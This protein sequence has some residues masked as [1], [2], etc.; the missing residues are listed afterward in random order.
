LTLNGRL[1]K[2]TWPGAAI[3]SLFD[4]IVGASEQR[5]WDG[6]TERLRG[7]EIDN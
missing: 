5:R 2:Q 6:Q 4:H 7:L 1:E 3:L